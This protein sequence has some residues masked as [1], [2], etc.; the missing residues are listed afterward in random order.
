MGKFETQAQNTSKVDFVW[1]WFGYPCRRGRIGALYL[2][3][4]VGAC[5]QSFTFLV[6]PYNRKI[7]Y[8]KLHLPNFEQ[9]ELVMKYLSEDSSQ[10]EMEKYGVLF[11]M[12]K[13]AFY[14]CRR[15]EL[16][17]NGWEG[18]KRKKTQN[19]LFSWWVNKHLLV[20]PH[21]DPASILWGGGW[22]WEWNV[23]W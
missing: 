9:H 8:S 18:K 4:R 17:W 7:N 21:C 10:S 13:N 20:I 22:G 14:R 1:S 5:I 19:Q 6:V 3:G 2:S 11:W 16:T 12:N 15:R 23:G